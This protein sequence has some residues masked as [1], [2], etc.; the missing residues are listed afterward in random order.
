M[1]VVRMMRRK[2]FKGM[3]LL[4]VVAL[5]VSLFPIGTFADSGISVTDDVYGD[6]TVT[7]S[8][9]GDSTVSNAVY[10]SDPSH[11][12]YMTLFSF[13]DEHGDSVR[14]ASITGYIG[15]GG[16]VF[17]PEI[18]DGYPVKSIHTGA[19]QGNS[20]ILSVVIPDGVISIWED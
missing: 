18:I 13:V 6:N 20:T 16:N 15:P 2:S 14:Y 7:D 17:I 10:D 8:V 3:A 4:L 5:L 1:R 9:Y 19:F 11:F 12:T